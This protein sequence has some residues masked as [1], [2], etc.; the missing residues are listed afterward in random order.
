MLPPPLARPLRKP[1]LAGLASTSGSCAAAM[2]AGSVRALCNALPIRSP[3]VPNRMDRKTAVPAVPPICRKNVADAV[4][5]PMSCGWHAFCDGQ[6]QR[7]HAE[8]E[9]EPEQRHDDAG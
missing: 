7:L 5:T 3:T 4:A 8:A 6:H 2:N 9:A 1:A